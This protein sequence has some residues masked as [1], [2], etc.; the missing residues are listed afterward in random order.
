ML[1]LKI[2]FFLSTMFFL[3]PGFCQNSGQNGLAVCTF[4]GG[5]ENLKGFTS[6]ENFFS[7]SNE[8]GIINVFFDGNSLSE[9]P[10]KQSRIEVTFSASTVEPFT[11]GNVI[12]DSPVIVNF[13]TGVESQGTSFLIVSQIESLHDPSNPQIELKTTKFLNQETDGTITITLP[14][15]F[16]IKNPK[17]MDILINKAYIDG[18][19]RKGI[20]ITKKEQRKIKRALKKAKSNG[21]VKINCEYSN[22]K[23]IN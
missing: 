23:V 5:T 15:T 20:K 16:I 9:E 10:N 2:L 3:L 8:F 4:E 14:E 21:P 12:M 18:D 13:L 17:V 1:I 19:I 6:E 22:I 7:F 11:V